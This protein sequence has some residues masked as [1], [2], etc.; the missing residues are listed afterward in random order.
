M[1]TSALRIVWLGAI[2]LGGGAAALAVINGCRTSGDESRV[3]MSRAAEALPPLAVRL[4]ETIDAATYGVRI[5]APADKATDEWDLSFAVS[6]VTETSGDE[7]ITL[8]RVYDPDPTGDPTDFFFSP[9]GAPYLAKGGRGAFDDKMLLPSAD[10]V[11]PP[12]SADA[13][14]GDGGDAGDAGDGGTPADWAKLAIGMRWHGSHNVP[15]DELAQHEWAGVREVPYYELVHG[16]KAGD[17]GYL[18][19][20]DVIGRNYIVP[21]VDL[22]TGNSEVEAL[23]GTP[24]AKPGPTFL[25]S[26]SAF[27]WIVDEHGNMIPYRVVTLVPAEARPEGP[28]WDWKSLRADPSTL[29]RVICLRDSELPTDLQALALRAHIPLGPDEDAVQRDKVALARLC[30]TGGPLPAFPPDGM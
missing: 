18:V 23:G 22:V 27:F 7:T 24:L 10:D 26:A 25:R 30:D 3:A 11:D 14:A 9:T 15:P 6:T 29:V 20:G 2:A 17:L 1:R 16:W 19:Q 4:P 21:Y 12:R 13:G 5:Y 8:R 28:E